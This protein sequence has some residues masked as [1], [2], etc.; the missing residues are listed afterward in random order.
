MSNALASTLQDTASVHTQKPCEIQ[1]PPSQA[2]DTHGASCAEPS[3]ENQPDINRD[4]ARSQ[5]DEAASTPTPPELQNAYRILRQLGHGA[6]GCVYL[7]KRLSDDTKVAIKQLRIDSIKTWK[8][9]TLFNREAEVLS[10]LQIPGVVKFYEALEYLN[11]EPP[12]SY[13][14]QEYVEGQTLKHLLQS[15]FRF[16]L[17]RV[18]EIALQLIDILEKLHSHEPP[19]IHRDIKPSNVIIQKQADDTLKVFLIDFGAVANPRIQNGGSTI[20]GT[21][22]YMSP[23]QYVGQPTPKSDTYALAAL[24]TYLISGM[25]PAEMP[26]RELRLII[27]PYVENQ[28]P[29]LV[30]TLRRMLEP[31]ISQRLADYDE[32]RQR[33]TRFRDGQFAIQNESVETITPRKLM[34]QLR[35]VKSICQPGN[36]E[37]WQALPDLPQNRAK[38]K[39]KTKSRQFFPKSRNLTR[40]EEQCVQMSFTTIIWFAVIVAVIL[41]ALFVHIP[42]LSHNGIIFIAFFI[43]FVILIP[44]VRSKHRDKLAY[45]ADTD[46][47]YKA[48][49]SSVTRCN[50]L[51]QIYTHGRKTIATITD[52]QFQARDCTVP[53]FY[54]FYKFNPPDDDTPNDIIH[55]IK[56]HIM[57]TGKFKVGDPLPILYTGSLDPDGVLRWVMSMPYPFP[58]RDVAYPNDYCHVLSKPVAVLVP[59]EDIEPDVEIQNNEMSEAESQEPPAQ[60]A[61]DDL[62]IE[63][64]CYSA[65][66]TNCVSA[67]A[68]QINRDDYIKYLDHQSDT[69]D[70]DTE[71]EGERYISSPYL[72]AIRKKEAQLFQSY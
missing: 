21:Y 20:A 60:K 55:C 35:K 43:I 54:I 13:I 64:A 69:H 52:I 63:I 17:A 25:D 41:I 5:T 12:C 42:Y 15:G 1:A 28:P 70:P 46:Y 32:L 23:E 38:I 31:D 47:Q 27:D 56:T 11:A 71:D 68:P 36:L 8:E 7:A 16:S 10:D 44:T 30:Q 40:F 3:P 45:I 49:T 65:E 58:I 6:Q 39:I 50:M 2:I 53:T 57:P 18:C 61:A 26:I 59:V 24:I 48:E 9:Y 67:D 29:E 51:E 4:A 72:R 66:T 33:F 14:I 37:M 34:K 22:G 62:D 19:V